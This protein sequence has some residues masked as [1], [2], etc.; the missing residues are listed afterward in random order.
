[1][2]GEDVDF[3]SLKGILENI[4]EAIHINHYDV[5]KEIN[6]ASYHPGRCANLKVGM[7]RIATIR[8]ST[9]RSIR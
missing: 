1:M 9:S 7:D 4:L 8:R 5:E 6:N 3:Y 2:Y